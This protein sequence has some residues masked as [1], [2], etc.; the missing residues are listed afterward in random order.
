[1]TL[2]INRITNEWTLM[3]TDWNF[4]ITHRFMSSIYVLA[5]FVLSTVNTCLVGENVVK[6]L[7]LDC[8]FVSVYL[9]LLSFVCVQIWCDLM[10]RYSKVKPRQEYCLRL[11]V[12]INRLI[13]KSWDSPRNISSH[14]WIFYLTIVFLIEAVSNFQLSAMTFILFELQ[15]FYLVLVRAVVQLNV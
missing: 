12:Y 1:M 11:L 7:L 15:Y 4:Y 14:F 9:C 6:L 5:I 3:D 10:L 8:C 13:R 2:G